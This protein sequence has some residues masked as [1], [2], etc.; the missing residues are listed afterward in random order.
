MTR[1]VFVLMP[2]LHLLDLAGPA[3]V[4]STATDFGHP[5]ELSYVGAEPVIPTHQGVP[6][7]ASVELPRLSPDD[8][9][10]ALS[11]RKIGVEKDVQCGGGEERTDSLR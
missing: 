6:L 9:L 3:Q 4:F 5:Y 11:H 10:L 2:R 7:G 1:V 8:L